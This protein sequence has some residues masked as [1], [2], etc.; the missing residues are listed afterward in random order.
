[1][2]NS[3]PKKTKQEPAPD[4]SPPD[5]LSPDDSLISPAM[6]K[7]LDGMTPLNRRNR[8]EIIQ[9][10]AEG[11]A[12]LWHINLLRADGLMTMP[13]D[14]TASRTGNDICESQGALAIRMAQHYTN[15]DGSN[16]LKF[17]ITKSLI[18]SWIGMKTPESAK[19][20][21]PGTVPGI[22]KRFSLKAWI[23]WFDKYLLP[24]KQNSS[25]TAKATDN[26]D[27]EDLNVLK[28]RDER[29]EY[30]LKKMLR[31]QKR[32]ELIHRS[33]A[34]AT[35]IRAVKELHLMVKAE[36]ERMHPKLRREKLIE[37]GTSPELA[38]AFSAWDK[39]QMRMA[40]DRREN[41]MA[42]IGFDFPKESK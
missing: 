15:P 4:T 13:K 38:E 9:K 3:E 21:P 25:Y 1:M 29:D 16:Q 31:D 33:I 24:T 30:R 39:E 37:L 8:I 28:Q 11:T 6:Q 35:G 26:P 34:E 42:V 14:D 20:P 12:S 27:E 22:G 18:G 23:A 2:K 32:G 10:V 7:I 17:K 5:D 40:T 41:A 36:D 19:N